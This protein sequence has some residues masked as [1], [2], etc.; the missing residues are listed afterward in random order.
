M[1]FGEFRIGTT[2]SAAIGSTKE[3]PRWAT[4]LKADRGSQFN[5]LAIRCASHGWTGRRAG[6]GDPAGIS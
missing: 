2:L 4:G 5:L 6:N 3:K 1:I